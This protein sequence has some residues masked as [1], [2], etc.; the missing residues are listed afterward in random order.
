MSNTSHHPRGRDV[1]HARIVEQFLI[2]SIEEF[3]MRLKKSWLLFVALLLFS[4]C[5]STSYSS[6]SVESS[7]SNNSLAKVSVQGIVEGKEILQTIDLDNCGGKS[8]AVRIEEMTMSVDVT[9]SSEIAASVGASAEVISAEVQRA[10]QSTFSQSGSKSMSIQLTAPPDTHMNFQIAWVGDERVGVVQNVADVSIPI[11]FRSFIPHDVRIKSQVD[12]GCPGQKEF[13]ESIIPIT[14]T[15]ISSPSNTSAPNPMP[16]KPIF[17]LV[18]MSGPFQ[19]HQVASVGTGVF[20]HVTYSDG[21]AHFTQDN[22]NTNYYHIQI[23]RPEDNPDGCGVS[24]YETDKVWFSGSAHTIFT[25]NG[26]EVGRLSIDTGSHGYIADWHIH[27]GDK[28][29][30]VGF[31]PSGFHVAMGPDIYYHYDSYCYRGF[32]HE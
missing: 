31:A 5:S 32:C 1:G 3:A 4:G 8:D 21:N 28:I 18:Q 22:L 27:V 14:A 11:A 13:Q 7:D 30:A 6:N 15:P 26:K 2:I 24:V 16:T 29:C 17:T 25:V 10:V 19:E 20:M 23:I 12:V 9:V